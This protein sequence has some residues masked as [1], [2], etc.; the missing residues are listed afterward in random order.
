MSTL[1]VYDTDHHKSIDVEYTVRFR[2][3]IDL[4][5]IW[6]SVHSVIRH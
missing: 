6:C 3:R 5:R 2:T 4:I 1:Y